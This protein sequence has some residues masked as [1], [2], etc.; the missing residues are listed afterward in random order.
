MQLLCTTIYY[1]SRV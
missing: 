1:T